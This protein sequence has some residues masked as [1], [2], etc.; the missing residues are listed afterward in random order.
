MLARS[1]MRL[2]TTDVL[3]F[4][5]SGTLFIVDAFTVMGTVAGAA[6]GPAGLVRALTRTLDA[7]GAPSAACSHVLTGTG[8]LPM[9]R[10][11]P[12]RVP[13]PC[14]SSV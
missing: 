5:W 11:H 14:E 1:W 4:T 9:D 6:V 12:L 13:V 10:P 8:S 7:C 3:E 2:I